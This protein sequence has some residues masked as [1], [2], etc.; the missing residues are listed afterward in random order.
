MPT[1]NSTLTKYLA[2]RFAVLIKKPFTEW[3]AFNQGL[4][5]KDG[6]VIKKP[7]TPEEKDALDTLSNLVRKIKKVM[8]KYIGDNKMI[9]FLIASY[10][11]KEDVSYDIDINSICSIEEQETLKNILEFLREK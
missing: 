4:I 9:N 8:V 2:Y 11:L 5:D 6:E 3:E 1:V 7:S 10:L